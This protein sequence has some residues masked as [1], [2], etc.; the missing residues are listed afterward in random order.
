MKKA[1]ILLTI[2]FTVSLTAT[3]SRRGNDVQNYPAV[4]YDFNPSILSVA[5]VDDPDTSFMSWLCSLWN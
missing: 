3:A 1:A 2:L 4:E 5:S